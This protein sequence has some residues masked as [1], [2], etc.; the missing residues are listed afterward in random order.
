[1]PT[2]L[3]NPVFEWVTDR[4]VGAY[5]APDRGREELVAGGRQGVSTFGLDAT[6]SVEGRTWVY[7]RR[8]DEWSEF[9]R[10]MPANAADV[11]TMAQGGQ[12]LPW[13]IVDDEVG[14]L[15]EGGCVL[16]AS[17]AN[18]VESATFSVRIDPVAG[19]VYAWHIERLRTDPAE[20]E[21][22]RESM[23]IEYAL[24]GADEFQPPASFR[25]A[26]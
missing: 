12:A 8:Q 26:P 24:P 17:L 16:S 1:M 7:D 18:E 5:L 25:P 21:G 4:S 14:L 6:V 9:E 19:R 15:G 22:Y 3:D 11:F 2:D 10:G 23:E 13:E 20:G